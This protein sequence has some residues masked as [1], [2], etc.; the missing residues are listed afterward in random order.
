M[1]PDEPEPDDE[2]PELDE[3]VEP[4][5][6]DPADVDPLP[7]ELE[8]D[9]DEPPNNPEI[10]VNFVS[11]LVPSEVI[12]GT[13]PIATNAAINAYSIVVTA[14]RA[15]RATFGNRRML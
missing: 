9:W 7:L 14:W 4:D 8:P 2:E 10:P 13:V 12:A 3:P 1:E 15:I 6:D 5:P 11:R